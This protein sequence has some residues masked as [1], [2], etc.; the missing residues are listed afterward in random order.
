MSRTLLGLALVC[1]AGLLGVTSA[2]DKGDKKG[3]LDDKT[4]VE[5][6]AAGNRHEVKMGET[7]SR[8][9]TATEV[10]EFA[11]KMV[12]DHTRSLEQLTTAAKAAGVEVPDK[13]SKE[14][15][16]EQ[17]RFDKMDGK[18]FD[19]AYARQMV[20]DHEKTL[21]LY[22]QAS[23]DLESTDLR[24]YAEKTVP[25][26]REHLEMA[27]KL[28]KTHGG[29]KDKGGDKDAKAKDADKDKPAK[30]RPFKDR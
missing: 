25:V 5:K 27:R 26:I 18:G 10:R 19:A 12:K 17:A 7:A 28:H 16:E 1:A 4:F 9:A 20:M 24:K 13:A 2:D 30:E 11:E 21:K 23:K 22:E 8:K 3:T 14:H 29:D 6:A 15:E